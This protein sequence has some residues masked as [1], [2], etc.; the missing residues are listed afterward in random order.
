MWTD[1]CSILKF[2]RKSSLK[3]FDNALIPEVFVKWEPE[4]ELLLA[5]TKVCKTCFTDGYTI[6]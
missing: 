5:G 2:N 3:S 1:K 6:L 4:N